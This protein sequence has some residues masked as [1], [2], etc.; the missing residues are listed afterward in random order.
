MFVILL[1]DI[2]VCTYFL[3]TTFVVLSNYK[4][5]LSEQTM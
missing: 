3:Q 5:L 4:M 2:Y 1:L